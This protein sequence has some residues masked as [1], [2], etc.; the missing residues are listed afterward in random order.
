MRE[1][2]LER[3]VSRVWKSNSHC[4]LIRHTQELT[5]FLVAVYAKCIRKD[6]TELWCEFGSYE[7]S[8]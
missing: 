2:G 7:K 8:L 4:K 5:W 3:G 1:K 6:I